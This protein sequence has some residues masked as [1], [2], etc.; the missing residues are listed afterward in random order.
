VSND[1]HE[2]RIEHGEDPGEACWVEGLFALLLDALAEAGRAHSDATVLFHAAVAERL[3][4]NPTDHKV[5]S[6]LERQG[7]LS[8][9]DIA[10][11]SGLATA[12]VTALV[13]RLEQRGLARRHP[14]PGDRRRVLV[15]A[16]AEGVARLEPYV[17]ARRDS[18]TR[19]YATY[20]VDELALTLDPLQRSTERLRGDVARLSAGHDR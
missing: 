9:G 15:E 7:P 20:T 14:D 17:A 12:S 19:L 5:M 4:L 13:D 6:I 3:G 1:L 8:A 10:Q 11:R 16:T 18:L 2:V